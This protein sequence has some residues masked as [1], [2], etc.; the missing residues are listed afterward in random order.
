M[1]QNGYT[2]HTALDNLADYLNGTFQA[3]GDNMLAFLTEIMNSPEE[4]SHSLEDAAE[5]E[6]TKTTFFDILGLAFF[7]YDRSVAKILAIVET[8]VFIV[9]A[10]VAL[11][12]LV[13]KCVTFAH[14]PSKCSPHSLFFLLVLRSYGEY[15][16]ILHVLLFQVVALFLFLFSLLMSILVTVALGAFMELVNP[17][18]WYSHIPMGLFFFAS[19]FL[20][21]LVSI[22]Y[23]ILFYFCRGSTPK[24]LCC[25]L[26]VPDANHG[27]QH[28]EMAN[29]E[30]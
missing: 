27:L 13:K 23:F 29:A 14:F 17:S 16:K 1:F 5:G 10:C 8:V 19:F 11:P 21:T 25:F 9:V 28:L 12:F 3:S 26:S 22:F 6:P 30:I 24:S 18:F 20:M 2:Y 15:N 7:T 4:L